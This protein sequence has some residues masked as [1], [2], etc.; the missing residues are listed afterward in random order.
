MNW[1]LWLSKTG[2]LNPDEVNRLEVYRRLRNSI[3][4]GDPSNL[5]GAPT[6]ELNALVRDLWKRWKIDEDD[7]PGQLTTVRK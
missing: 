4:H 6:D 1:R 5:K 2:D 3:V 7:P